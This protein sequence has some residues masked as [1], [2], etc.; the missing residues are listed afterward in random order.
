MQ[1]VL[2]PDPSSNPFRLTP[3][4][5][6]SFLPEVVA[7]LDARAAAYDA[8]EKVLHGKPDADPKVAA[9][10]ERQAKARRAHRAAREARVAKGVV[11]RRPIGVWSKRSPV[12]HVR[13]AARAPRRA[14]RVRVGRSS[15]RAGPTDGPAPG[16][17]GPSS[18][19][20]GAK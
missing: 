16:E 6:A 10:M 17:D 1:N 5:R 12:R 19:D 8:R 18:V 11:L 3:E 9:E 20:R 2:P 14:R 7:K 13:H 4:Q 15:V